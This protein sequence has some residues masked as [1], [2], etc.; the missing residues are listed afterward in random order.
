[1]NEKLIPPGW[2]KDHVTRYLDTCR[3]NQLATFANKR[4]QVIDL[5]SIDG[6]FRKLV[7]GAI[8]PKPLLPMVFLLRAHSA[9][10]NA[11]GAVMAGQLHE[12]QALLRVSLEQAGYGHFIG[13]DQERWERWMNRHEPR[14][15]S[16]QDKWRKEFSNGTIARHLTSAD[17]TLGG[18]Y[19]ELYNRTIDY[20]GHPNERGMSMSTDIVDLPDGGE[21]TQAL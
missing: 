1:M 6:M 9:F 2:R 18:I 4:S 13:D 15:R 12:A 5:I 8:D 20:G 17:P 10:L 11:V 19:T 7:D 16:Q 14:T 21:Q 3:G